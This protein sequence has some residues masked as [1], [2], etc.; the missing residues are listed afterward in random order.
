L[1]CLREAAS[2][3]AGASNLVF[4][5]PYRKN[6]SERRLGVLKE[7]YSG[8]FMRLVTQVASILQTPLHAMSNITHKKC[9]KPA[10]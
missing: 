3:E 5:L 7:L 4:P 6:R 1:A 10:W 9:Q 8:T 2:A